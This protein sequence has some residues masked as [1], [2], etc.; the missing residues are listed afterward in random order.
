MK[1]LTL[2]L[3]FFAAGL[4]GQAQAFDMAIPLNCS[5]AS[6]QTDACKI[7]AQCGSTQERL[8]ALV[9]SQWDLQTALLQ[10]NITDDERRRYKKRL[11]K[12]DRALKRVRARLERCTAKALS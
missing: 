3:A 10:E 2:S 9:G 5:G 6:A 8:S 1:Y 12:H 7:Q 11:R 4:A